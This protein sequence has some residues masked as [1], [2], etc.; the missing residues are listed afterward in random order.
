MKATPDLEQ[1]KEQFEALMSQSA[2]G[3]KEAMPS[4]SQDEIESFYAVAFSFYENGKYPEAINFF[5]FLTTIDLTKKKH[6]VG[7]GASLQML[8]EQEQ[9][10]N[11]YTI[12]ALLD[13]ADPYI[14]FYAAECCFKLGDTKRGLDALDS[15]E[16]LAGTDDKFKGLRKRLYILREAW[17]SI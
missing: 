11:A 17:T 13:P 14:P 4:F 1:L 15:A 12:A 7:L 5:R 9:A 3:V 2:E 16:E 10:I 8:Q 6:W